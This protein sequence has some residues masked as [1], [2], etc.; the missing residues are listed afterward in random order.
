MKKLSPTEHNTVVAALDAF[1]AEHGAVA[2]NGLLMKLSIDSNVE[3]SNSSVATLWN[4][5]DVLR[6]A[7]GGD[8]H[9]GLNEIAQSAYGKNKP[10]AKTAFAPAVDSE[11]TADAL[12]KM[13]EAYNARNRNPDQ[14]KAPEV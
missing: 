14:D 13:G 12:N 5:L 7:K 3:L 9:A 8:L 6:R 1:K 10:E 4:H 2:L 11:S